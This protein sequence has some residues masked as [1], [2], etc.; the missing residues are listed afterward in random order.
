MALTTTAKV[1]T[2]LGVRGTGDDARWDALRVAAEAVAKSFCK[3][4]VESA[5]YTEY[6]DGNGTRHLALR[7]R[8]V[9]A[10]TSVEVA[11]FGSYGQG[12]ESPYVAWTAGVDWALEYT[13]TGPANSSK[14]GVLVRLKGNWPEHR[15]A[16]R[17]G[18]LAWERVPGLG[19]VRVVY[20]AGYTTIPDDL[21]LAVA[22]I[23]GYLFRTSY[24]G[25]RDYGERL[26]DHSYMVPMARIREAPELGSVRQILTRYRE[27]PW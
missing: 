20:T 25:G 11:Q 5:S 4:D 10:V 8:P 16:V 26:G 1:K 9:T 14:T 17:D 27:L 7:R 24:R 22:E 15:S 6:L 2:L 13:A 3:A 19:N 21:Q 18:T 12:N 23:C